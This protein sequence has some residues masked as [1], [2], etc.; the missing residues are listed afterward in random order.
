MLINKKNSIPLNVDEDR[1]TFSS[2]SH[3]RN[4]VM[5]EREN[6]PFTKTNTTPY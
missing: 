3:S 5:S 1:N 2:N 6:I 4:F